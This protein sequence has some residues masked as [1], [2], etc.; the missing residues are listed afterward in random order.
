MKKDFDKWNEYKKY[1]NSIE[2]DNYFKERDIFW[3][4]IWLNVK[5]EAIWKWE[6]FRRPIL[7]F[8]KLSHDTC[9]WI[10]LSTKIKSWTW[11]YNYKIDWKE[12]T[13]L[14]YQMRMFHKNRFGYKI[15]EFRES[16][17]IE[18]KKKLKKLLSF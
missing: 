1:L 4:S 10:P 11:F 5:S 15:W 8:K 6:K 14:L 18:I 2:L 13:A 7:V 3:C 12:Y 16:S 9:F 17:F